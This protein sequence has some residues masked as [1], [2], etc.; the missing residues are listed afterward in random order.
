MRS[1]ADVWICGRCRSL[2]SIGKDRCYKCNTPKEV[3]ATRPEDLSIHAPQQVVETPTG[4]FRSSETLAVAVG[5]GTFLFIAAGLVARLTF[6]DALDRLLG[7]HADDAG[8]LLVDRLPILALAPITAVLGL[9]L[10]G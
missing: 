9:V 2:N 10:Y 4:T 7:G 5:I 3:A 6:A 1:G 8:A